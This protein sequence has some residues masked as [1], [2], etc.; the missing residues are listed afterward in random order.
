[1]ENENPW[2][3]FGGF[4]VYYGHMAKIDEKHITTLKTKAEAK[5]EVLR[6]LKAWRAL[7]GIWRNKKIQNPVVWQRKIRKESERA[8]P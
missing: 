1:M 6:D 7:W 4:F 3:D 2:L 8:L 5:Y